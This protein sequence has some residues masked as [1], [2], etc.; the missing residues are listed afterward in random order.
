[1][2]DLLARYLDG[3]L[4]ED[5]ADALIRAADDDPLVAARLRDYETILSV[6]GELPRLPAPDNL[7]DRVMKRIDRR[8]PDH[9][10][11]AAF[12]PAAAALLLGL[13]AG[14]FAAPRDS[15][16]LERAQTGPPPA[17]VFSTASPAPVQPGVQT[18]RAV[19]LTYTPTRTE[20]DKVSVAGSFNGWDPANAPMSKHGDVWTILLVLPPGSY[21]YMVIEDGEHWVTDPSAPETRDDGFGGVNGLLEVRS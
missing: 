20:T 7:A 1:M 21:E 19:R 5:E 15:S 14:Y 8:R 16:Q 6:S 13:T 18:Y 4:A 10:R 17:V 2:E 9:A 11:F 12:W 3:D